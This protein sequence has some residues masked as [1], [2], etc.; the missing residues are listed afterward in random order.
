MNFYINKHNK[1]TQDKLRVLKSKNPKDFWKI[2]N[3]IQKSKDN[4]NIDIE[5]LYDFFKKFK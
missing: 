3:S 1:I 4:Q 5:I 2:I